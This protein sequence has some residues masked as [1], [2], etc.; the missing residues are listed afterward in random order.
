MRLGDDGV[1]LLCCQVWRIANGTGL[2]SGSSFSI[3][4]WV[5]EEGPRIAPVTH[6][7]FIGVGGSFND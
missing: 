4:H 2:L 7:C 3:P 5:E 6:W 1:Q